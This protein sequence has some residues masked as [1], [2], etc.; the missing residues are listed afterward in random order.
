MKLDPNVNPG[1]LGGVVATRLKLVAGEVN[2]GSR[3]A[4]IADFASVRSDH[5][6]L[7]PLG[8]IALLKGSTW[9][10]VKLRRRLDP[11]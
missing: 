7:P 11:P 3:M 10:D 5:E 8:I 6:K 2:C 4:P 9:H 1:G